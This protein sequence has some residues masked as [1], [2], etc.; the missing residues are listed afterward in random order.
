MR[1]EKIDYNNKSTRDKLNILESQLNYFTNLNAE[2]YYNK[3]NNCYELYTDNELVARS[4]EVNFLKLGIIYNIPEPN[5]NIK[6]NHP[7]T[8]DCNFL[9]LPL[10]RLY[11][12]CDTLCI[13]RDMFKEQIA[14]GECPAYNIG[15][16][17]LDI[18]IL[19]KLYHTISDH[20]GYD[21]DKA[22]QQMLKKANKK[23]DIGED[24]MILAVKGKKNLD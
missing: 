8:D 19:D 21:R 2:L 9:K 23:H 3:T 1:I 11:T 17:K 12:I 6:Y 18:D 16:K 13:V 24:G 10:G 14:K 4:L 20:V 22:I 7:G 15:F 5:V